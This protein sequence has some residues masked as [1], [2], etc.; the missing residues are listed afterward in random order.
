MVAMGEHRRQEAV[1]YFR[2]L[3]RGRLPGGADEE[4]IAVWDTLV[5]AATDLYPQEL[6]PE[7]KDAF[8]EELIS[9]FFVNIED[10]DLVL[11]QGQE[12]VLA[13]LAGKYPPITDTVFE[14]ASWACFEDDYRER[15][16]HWER[17][18]A[19]RLLPRSNPSKS[20]L[21]TTSPSSPGQRGYRAA[22]SI[23]REG[24]KPGRNDPCSCGSG[25][26]YKKCCGKATP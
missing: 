3:M 12:A 10:V 1:D 2:D 21:A 4:D 25:K 14:M 7:I 26:K 16:E 11:K 24:P 20:P 23:I 22:G 18:A 19:R 9:W 17:A 8:Q 13:E 5:S 6:Y 15:K